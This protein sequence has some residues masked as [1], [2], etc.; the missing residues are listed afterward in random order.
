MTFKTKAT[1]LIALSLLLAPLAL[2][3]FQTVEKVYAED[4]VEEIIPEEAPI[5]DNHARLYLNKRQY[6]SIP[7]KQQN[8]GEEML[9]F[10][11]EPLAGVSF[12]IYGISQAMYNARVVN[13]HSIEEITDAEIILD[14]S[15]FGPTIA[16]IQ[17]AN[18]DILGSAPLDYFH[19]T[20]KTKIDGLT[21]FDVPK[22]TEVR[23]S[24]GTPISVDSA[25]YITEKDHPAN[26]VQVS[27]PMLLMFP[28][29]EMNLNG[30][31]TDNELN[32]IYL[33]P[34]NVTGTG[35]VLVNKVTQGKEDNV[36]LA[37]A[38]FKVKNWVFVNDTQTYSQYLGPIDEKTGIRTWG[39]FADAEEFTTNVAGQVSI[40]DIPRSSY[41][42][43]FFFLEE[44]RVEDDDNT[45]PEWNKEL[46]FILDGDMVTATQQDGDEEKEVKYD[47]VFDDNLPLDWYNVDGTIVNNNLVVEKSVD[48]IILGNGDSATYTVDFNVPTDI[49]YPL[50][51]EDKYIDFFLFD[52]HD[53]ALK[54][55]DEDAIRFFSYNANGEKETI[56]FVADVDYEVY[57]LSADETSE[58]L[59]MY[60]SITERGE[61]ELPA[62]ELPQDKDYFGIRWLHADSAFAHYV[63][64]R[65]SVEYQLQLVDKEVADISLPN[66]ATIQTGYE[67]E[68]SDT[69]VFTGG[70]QFIKVD[71]NMNVP[72]SGAKFYLQ[73]GDQFLFQKSEESSDELY[74]W[75]TAQLDE[76]N[77]PA[78][79]DGYVLVSLESDDNGY[80]EI[81][82]LDY[83]GEF[84]KDGKVSGSTTYTLMEYA[85]P[86]DRYILPETGFSFKVSFGSYLAGNEE[87]GKERI[88]NKEKTPLPSTGGMGT[89]VFFLVGATTMA[90]VV[91]LVRKKKSV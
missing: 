84:D 86:S 8:I 36:P 56:N 35:N 81:Q 79:P 54:L 80:F 83:A 29:Y 16:K 23:A 20:D 34:K 1:Q 39:S 66:T 30:T 43:E 40:M 19:F 88:A 55:A 25:Y 87:L 51:I 49:N 78:A 37:G 3:A 64:K 24:D 52:A 9:D 75:A 71:M 15:D 44:V 65:V 42:A 27:A 67:K 6:D 21:I 73:N 72:L 41:D 38:V 53:P 7:S 61:N 70:K 91:Y 11:G 47:F 85:T 74:H 4:G 12:N 63:G 45:I 10:G 50:S 68:S 58:L 77:L 46:C 18:G 13:H 62:E 76:N 90:G 5:P 17:A 31:Y 69:E 48:D 26:V 57:T 82:G 59:A 60:N 14:T 28:V 2:S 32:R 22:E 33:Y 89:I